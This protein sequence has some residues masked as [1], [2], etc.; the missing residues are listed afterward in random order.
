MS[1]KAKSA[2]KER[3]LKAKRAKKAAERARYEEYQRLGQNRKSKRVRLASRRK[4][5][6]LKEKE[7][8]LVPVFVKGRWILELRRFH[9]GGRCG[10]AR[11]KRCAEYWQPIR[12]LMRVHILGR[13]EGGAPVVEMHVVF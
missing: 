11:C 4:G 8:T 5:N 13:R 3:R 2:T 6:A 1:K 12:R 9:R 10:N 7:W